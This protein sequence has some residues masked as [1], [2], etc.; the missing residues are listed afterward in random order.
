[1]NNA[2]FF[3][4]GDALAQEFDYSAARRSAQIYKSEHEIQGGLVVAQDELGRYAVF[5]ESDAAPSSQLL[6]AGKSRYTILERL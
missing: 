4:Q 1:M 6:E 5:Y 2:I 3:N